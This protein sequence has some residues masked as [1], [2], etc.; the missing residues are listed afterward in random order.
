MTASIEE[1]IKAIEDEIFNT[2]KNKATEHHIGKLKA[3]IARL[4]IEAEKRKTFFL[5][6]PTFSFFCFDFK[7]CY[8]CF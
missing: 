1:Q 4:K 2:Q 3:K 7:P 8:L 5:R 6:S